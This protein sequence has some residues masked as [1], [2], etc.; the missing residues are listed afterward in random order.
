MAEF[1]AALGVSDPDH[2]ELLQKQGDVPDLDAGMEGTGRPVSGRP[3]SAQRTHGQPLGL[4]RHQDQLPA[5][6]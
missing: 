5:S 6:P 2:L 4:V 3:S 1:A